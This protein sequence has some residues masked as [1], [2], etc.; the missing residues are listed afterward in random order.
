[1][2][3][4]L[5][6]R[7]RGAYRV[8]PCSRLAAFRCAQRMT[9]PEFAAILGVGERH[10]RRIEASGFIADHYVTKLATR[11]GIDLEALSA[12]LE[13]EGIEVSRALG[14]AS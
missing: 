13:G 1:M 7:R 8:E 5:S 9:Q 3:R 10:Y 2:S 12:Q 11:F 14:A 6:S 4:E